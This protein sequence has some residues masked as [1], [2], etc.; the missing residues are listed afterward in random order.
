MPTYG[1]GLILIVDDPSPLEPWTFVQFFDSDARR[2]CKTTKTEG[3][4]VIE[5]PSTDSEKIKF[6]KDDVFGVMY[7][8]EDRYRR[9]EAVYE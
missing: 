5:V 6:L 9:L 8:S 1:V 3:K 2:G 7:V 4:L